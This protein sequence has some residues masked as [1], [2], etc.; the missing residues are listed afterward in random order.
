M[1]D[2]TYLVL[3]VLHIAFAATMFGAPLSVG[4]NLKRASG[5]GRDVKA[6]AAA[7]AARMSSVA[8]ISAI[9]TAAFGLALVFYRGGFKA[10]PPTVHAALGLVL[11][12]I[13]IGAIMLRPLYKRMAES[14]DKPNEVW[15]ALRKRNAML[16][17]ILQL[18]WFVT[19]VLMFVKPNVG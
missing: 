8:G 16:Q 5:A 4:S 3:V 7:L 12:M 10:V 1:A 19:L 11:I 14:T 18:L 2:P 17:G 9:L 6:A 15:E 13:A